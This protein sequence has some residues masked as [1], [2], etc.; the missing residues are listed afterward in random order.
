MYFHNI[1]YYY[2]YNAR[3]RI[4]IAGIKKQNEKIEICTQTI[5]PRKFVH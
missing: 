3:A 5:G 4:I 2:F 1:L